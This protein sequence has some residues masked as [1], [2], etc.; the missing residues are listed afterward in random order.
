MNVA[1]NAGGVIILNDCHFAGFDAWED[2]ASTIVFVD[3]VNAAATSGLMV[4]ATT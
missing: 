2:V 1:S 4:A 3:N